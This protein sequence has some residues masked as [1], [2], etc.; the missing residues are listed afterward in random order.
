MSQKEKREQIRIGIRLGN[1]SPPHP[2]QS[3]GFPPVGGP[4]ETEKK[5]PQ[6]DEAILPP[7]NPTESES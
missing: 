4:T 6:G 7:E 3:I 5:Y 1:T 2:D